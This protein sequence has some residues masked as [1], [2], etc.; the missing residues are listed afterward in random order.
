MTTAT[1]AVDYNIVPLRSTKKGEYIRRIDRHGNMRKTTYIR[2]DYDKGSKTYSCTDAEDT[3]REV[4][5]KGD[6]IVAVDFTY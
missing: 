3:N 4:F 1:L 5:L 2:G 6:T